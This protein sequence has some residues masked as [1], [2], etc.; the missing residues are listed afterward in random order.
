MTTNNCNSF[1]DSYRFILFKTSHSTQ[2]D[3]MKFKVDGLH[4]LTHIML[5]FF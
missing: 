1:T 2:D 3:R 4:L 5:D